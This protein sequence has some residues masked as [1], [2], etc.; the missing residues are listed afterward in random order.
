MRPLR[1]RSEQT[2]AGSLLLA[3][4]VL[5]DPNFARSVV[6]LSAHTP[7][8][9]ALGV[10]LNQPVGKTL[11]ELDERF[12]NGPLAQV[13]VHIGGPVEQEQMILV[14]W[15]NEGDGGV[16]RL[17]FG[18]E[19][20]KAIAMLAEIPGLELRG[21]LGY[22]GW[23]PGQ[24][25]KELQQNTWV[26]AAVAVDAISGEGGRKMWRQ[27]LGECREDLLLQADTPEDPSVN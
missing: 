27:L 7:E 6:L 25:E 5:K 11:G 1:P 26:V 16:F 24:L 13:S 15:H 20:Q 3:H 9:G 22:S 2:L 18:V 4:P 19:E 23:S 8:D 17:Y 10:V 21:F 12:E 14:A